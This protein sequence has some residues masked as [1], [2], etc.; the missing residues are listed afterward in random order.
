MV[1]TWK[2]YKNC[3]FGWF[4]KTTKWAF[5]WEKTWRNIALS[6]GDF[7]GLVWLPAGTFSGPCSMYQ[8]PE[9][10]PVFLDSATRKWKIGD[11]TA[12]P[13]NGVW[14]WSRSQ[15]Q[16]VEIHGEHDDKSLG[17]EVLHFRQTQMRVEWQGCLQATMKLTSVLPLHLRKFGILLA[18]CRYLRMYGN[19]SLFLMCPNKSFQK[20]AMPWQYR[21]HLNFQGEPLSPL[22]PSPRTLVD[23]A[24]AGN[25]AFFGDVH[26]DNIMVTNKQTTG[27][28][29][30]EFWWDKN[31]CQIRLIK[32]GHVSILMWTRILTN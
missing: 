19:S 18:T 17:F 14:K 11:Q 12:R 9:S 31:C 10:G 6:L 8:V 3:W 13:E 15:N 24:R 1:Y 7:P 25:P 4:Q 28:T 2:S 16:H 23:T 22:S 30:K 5:Q 32:S 29:K 21:W 27:R 20:W 26:E